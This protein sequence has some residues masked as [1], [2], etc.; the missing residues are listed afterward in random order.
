MDSSAWQIQLF[1]VRNGAL[2]AHPRLEHFVCYAYLE[3]LS[4]NS[5]VLLQEEAWIWC[6]VENHGPRAALG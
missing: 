4:T 3:F 5:V 6:S 2:R 1:L